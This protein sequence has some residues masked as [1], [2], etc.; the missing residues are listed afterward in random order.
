MQE[1]DVNTS[2]GAIDRIGPDKSPRAIATRWLKELD[3]VLKSKDYKQFVNQ[4]ERAVK[5]YRNADVMVPNA[6]EAAA[7]R[8]WYNIL[9]S[10]VQ[11]LK[12]TLY[13][14]LPKIVVERRFKDSDP[15]GRLASQV[16]ERATSYQLSTEQDRTNSAFKS[17]VEDRLLPGLGQV[18]VKYSA[19]FETLTGQDGQ[20]V[21]DEDETPQKI[22]K[23]NSEKATIETLYWQDY[24]HSTARN[25]YEI[26]WQAVRSYMN[27]Q[28]LIERFGDI[29]KK[30]K[31]QSD[32]RKKNKNLEDDTAE[33]FREAEVWE[34]WDKDTKTVYWISE[35]CPDCPLDQQPDPL[36]LKDFFPF[37]VPLLATTT[38]NSTLPVSDYAIY[39]RLAAELDNV[40]RR[41][42]G[43]A[44]CIRFVGATAAAYNTDIK[45]M[46]KLYDGQLWPIENWANLVERG[47]FKGV[48]DW[49]PFENAATVLPILMQYRDDLIEKINA[50][51]GIPDIAQGATD[52]NET[53]GAVQEKSR[54]TIVKVA[55]KQAD[56]QRFCR[57][58]IAKV[59][60]IIFEPGLFSDET[61][62][63]MCGL[64]QMSDDDR[65]MFPQALQ[66]LREDRLR[67]FRVDIETDS[68][69]AVDEDADKQ[70]RMEYLQAINNSVLANLQTVSQ[71]RPELM[72][73]MIE[74]A[75]FATR[76]FR[77]GR[78]L[79]GAWEAAMKQIED[80]DA[81]AA[82]NPEPPPPDPAMI[83][84][85]NDAQ[86]VQIEARKVQLLENEAQLKYAAEQLDTQEKQMISQA[87]VQKVNTEAQ[88]I[89]ER[90]LV[91][92]ER[93]NLEA[94]KTQ[95]DFELKTKELEIKGL[96]VQSEA[97]AKAMSAD[98]D[99]F[100]EQFAQYI[101]A[102][103]V[104]L[105]KV[106][107]M[108]NLKESLLE[109]TRLKNEQTLEAI[110]LTQDHIASMHQA[111]LSKEAT[112][113]PQLPP[114]HVHVSGGKKK[115]MRDKNG[116]IES[117]VEEQQDE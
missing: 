49:L 90:V 101:E 83:A 95:L 65:A 106:V 11:I 104:E 12:P 79:E 96:S 58:A 34:I 31:L 24:C 26:R 29:G 85:Q 69:I 87:E 41:I 38:T 2:G 53:L 99:R 39:K 44:D 57:E 43:M 102:Q 47:G 71:F 59:A 86:R 74:S 46:L 37:P 16:C 32:G 113:A 116:D 89:Y 111:S 35:G 23:P 51:T 7:S 107:S 50:I 80:N 5:D 8:I 28:K 103:R 61:I 22:V 88:A 94:Q 78:P 98:L 91:E 110:R 36:R 62:A 45:N 82:A 4:G 48:I 109:E 84:A 55:E 73:P 114:I 117:I 25:C 64:E 56:V 3:L 10:N 68:T 108:A 100:K 60:E 63:L 81:Q 33:F 72:H 67:T 19:D 93:L 105:E 52:P 76:A 1:S 9:W 54:W 70:A 30:V 40:T 27:R 15:I 17:A 13:A 75:L 115:I 77:Q 92:R 97:Q 6:S 18:M 20:A 42:S 112:K 21:L 14:R 66:L